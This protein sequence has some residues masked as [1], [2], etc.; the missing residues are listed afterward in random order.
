MQ[1]I[2]ST[3]IHLLFTPTTPFTPLHYDSFRNSCLFLKVNPCVFFFNPINV[4][5]KYMFIG[6]STG[7]CAK[8]Q[9]L[10]LRQKVTSF[11]NSQ[12]LPIVPPLGMRS[13]EPFVTHAQI[14]SEL[15]LCRVVAQL[16]W[17]GVCH[18]HVTPRRRYWHFAAPLP[19]LQLL[20]LPEEV[21][22]L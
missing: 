17:V 2:C 20:F 6:S 9:G 5:Y 1:T 10:H 3:H 13:Q 19:I 7:A 12:Q 18:T 16:L 8:R 14:L 4:V 22:C 11:P 15:M 21:F